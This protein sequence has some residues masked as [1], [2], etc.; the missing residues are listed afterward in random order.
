VKTNFGNLEEIIQLICWRQNSLVEGYA[1]V[2]D[3]RLGPGFVSLSL[4]RWKWS[5]FQQCLG[6]DILWWECS[7]VVSR[8]LLVAGSGERGAAALPFVWG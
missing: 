8:L 4:P 5:W 2:L 3:K 7:C 6:F 1:F